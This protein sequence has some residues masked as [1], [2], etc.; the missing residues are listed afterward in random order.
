MKDLLAMTGA[1][2]ILDVINSLPLEKIVNIIATVITLVLAVI[3]FGIKLHKALKD[4]K[5]TEA[6]KQELKDAS[7][8]VVITGKEALAICKALEESKKD[9]A[10]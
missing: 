2:I 5:I 8:F 4:G 9:G 3:L 6:E 10:K 7:E 1:S